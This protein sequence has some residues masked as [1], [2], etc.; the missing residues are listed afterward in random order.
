MVVVPLELASE[1]CIGS[2]QEK[3]KGGDHLWG[4]GMGWGM[5]WGMVCVGIPEKSNQRESPVWEGW[6]DGQYFI[7][8]SPIPKIF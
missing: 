5:G 1:G 4:V 2:E 8:S 3:N 6:M 7:A